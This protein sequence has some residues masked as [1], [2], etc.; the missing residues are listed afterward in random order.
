MVIEEE[1]FAEQQIPVAHN[2]GRILRSQAVTLYRATIQ[3]WT[4]E[5]ELCVYSECC[6]GD[7]LV[8]LERHLLN[9]IQ[10]TSISGV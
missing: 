10:N 2:E 5:M 1:E 3:D 9:S 7:V 4:P 8:K 6:F